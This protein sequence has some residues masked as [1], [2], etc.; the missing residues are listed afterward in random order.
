MGSASSALVQASNRVQAAADFGPGRQS[1]VHQ[2][3]AEFT[4]ATGQQQTTEAHSTRAVTL[5]PGQSASVSLQFY[6]KAPLNSKEQRKTES[7][8]SIPGLVVCCPMDLP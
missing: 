4:R 5:P 3:R 8:S 7:F 6:R 1:R 2:A